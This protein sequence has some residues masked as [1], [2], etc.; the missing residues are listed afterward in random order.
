MFT[1]AKDTKKNMNKE[2]M[3]FQL[4]FGIKVHMYPPFAKSVII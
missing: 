4:G 2:I 3:H 1:Y